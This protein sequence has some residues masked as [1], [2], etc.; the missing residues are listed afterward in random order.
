V[1]PD[2]LAVSERIKKTLER[3]LSSYWQ[4]AT[5]DLLAQRFAFQQLRDQIRRAF[6]G[7]HLK[8]GKNVGMVQRRRGSRLLLEAAQPVGMSEDGKTL[9][10]TSRPSRESRARYTSP[11]P[12]APTRDFTSYSPS[13]V[14]DVSVTRG[15]YDCRKVERTSALESSRFRLP[16][17]KIDRTNKRD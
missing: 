11:M 14:P 15:V 16:G 8:H 3:T 6:V 1:Y 9:I 7:A 17:V 13:L 12:P 2:L 10:A 5:L 4:A